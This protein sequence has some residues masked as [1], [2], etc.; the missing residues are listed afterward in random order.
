M[1][2][3]PFRNTPTDAVRAEPARLDYGVVEPPVDSDDGDV[4]AATFV[5]NVMVQTTGLD[6]E[7]VG[8]V[9]ST[10]KFFD[11]N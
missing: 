2:T 7:G 10:E 6:C 4:L 1:E 8:A 3:H 11:P 9:R 5:V